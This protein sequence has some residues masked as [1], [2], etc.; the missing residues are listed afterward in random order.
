MG[1]DRAPWFD[2]KAFS[3]PVVEA[4]AESDGYLPGNVHMD[5][6]YSF[7]WQH[8]CLIVIHRLGPSHSPQSRGRLDSL[9]FHT[10]LEAQVWML[11]YKLLLLSCGFLRA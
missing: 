6:L 2:T 7:D 4:Y 3:L 1:C 8:C 9:R 11:G 5:W 10:V